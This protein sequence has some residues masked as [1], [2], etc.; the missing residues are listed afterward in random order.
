MNFLRTL[1]ALV[2]F[3]T[4]TPASA[5][6]ILGVND[7]ANNG[8]EWTESGNTISIENLSNYDARITS[9][10]FDASSTILGLISV[11]GTAIDADWEFVINQTVN[12]TGGGD[13]DYG[14]TTQDNG[15][16]SMQ[17]LGGDA[18]SGIVVDMTGVFTFS[19]LGG[20]SFDDIIISDRF[21]RFQQTGADGNGSDRGRICTDVDCN[22][23]EDVPEPSII[24]LFGLGLFGL[25]LARRRKRS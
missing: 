8:A 1:T 12:G 19:L 15:N 6:L 10:A 16:P 7:P 11:A 13:F 21:V 4:V 23:P 22:P 9:F 24:A 3:L 14:S 2:M 25:G 20:L 18:N 5:V 17:L